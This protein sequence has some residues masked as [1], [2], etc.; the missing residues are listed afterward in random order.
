MLSNAVTIVVVLISFIMLPLKR[1]APFRR[2]LAA[3]VEQALLKTVSP[4]FNGSV[5]LAHNFKLC[6]ADEN[7]ETGEPL[8]KLVEALGHFR[9]Y[10]QRALSQN[11]QLFTRTKELDVSTQLQLQSLE[12]FNK[13]ELVNT[14]ITSNSATIKLL[15]EYTLSTLHAQ[16]PEYLKDLET[17]GK[18]LGYRVHAKNPAIVEETEKVVLPGYKSKQSKVIQSTSHILRDWHPDYAVERKPLINYITE[19]LS[20]IPQNNRTLVLI[21]GSGCGG[22]ACQIAMKFPYM[23]VNSIELDPFMYLCNEFVL[24]SKKNISL[25]PFAQD[26][27]NHGDAETQVKEFKLNLSDLNKPKNLKTH[28]GDFTKFIPQSDYDNVVVVSV[29]F[30]DTAENIFTY[31]E[32]IERMKKYCNNLSW[33][34]IGPL[35][36][37]TRPLVQFT[38]EELA[39]LRRIRGWT[40]KNA[41]VTKKCQNGY[42]TNYNSL[43]QAYYGLVSFY[44]VYK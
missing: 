31:F 14:S 33:I 5:Q 3:K 32:A 15:V 24:G 26:F 7:F 12:Y 25:R 28:W 37:G 8:S 38:V 4:S 44:S 39:A 19:N 35:K 20:G 36:Y 30:I 1:Y 11:A 23:E 10:E 29:Y 16:N 6:Q 22:I 42:V 18:R 17:V 2:W 34:N 43:F 27:S 9:E 13:L 40:D 21:P 41:K